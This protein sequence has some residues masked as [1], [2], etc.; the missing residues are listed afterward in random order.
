LPAEQ[1]AIAN[2]KH[3]NEFNIKN[4]TYFR[5]QIKRCGFDY[6]DNKEINGTDPEYYK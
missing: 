1:F 5:S 3:P 4:I 2:G 6:A